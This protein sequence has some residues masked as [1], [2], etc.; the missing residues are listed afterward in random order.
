VP[1]AGLTPTAEAAQNENRLSSDY[2]LFFA[3]IADL[4]LM[5]DHPELPAID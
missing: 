2:V 4:I 5:L 3:T 1:T